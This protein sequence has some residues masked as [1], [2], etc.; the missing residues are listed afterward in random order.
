MVG[1]PSDRIDAV[2]E[3]PA[4]INGWRGTACS[5]DRI[6]KRVNKLD[7]TGESMRSISLLWEMTDVGGRLAGMISSARFVKKASLHA[8]TC[9]H[10]LKGIS[11]KYLLYTPF[12]SRMRIISNVPLTND[13]QIC[14]CKT[15]YY[16]LQSFQTLSCYSNL[17]GSPVPFPSSYTC[18]SITCFPC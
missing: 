18:F 12:L 1:H 8:W 9:F 7:G 3:I 2:I 4:A 6:R 13:R 15:F 10:G 17:Q 11:N 16:L 14:Y 5:Y